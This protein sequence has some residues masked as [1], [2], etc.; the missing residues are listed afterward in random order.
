MAKRHQFG[1]ELEKQVTDIV[2]GEV[3]AGGQ[4][5]QQEIDDFQA[6]IDLF[7]A[8]RAE[9]DYQWMS[10]IFLPEFPAH[11]LTQ[12]SI[13]VAQYFQTRDFCEVYIQDESP[14]ALDAAEATKE[15]LNRTLNRRD[16]YHY[17]K[18]VRAKN[19]NHFKGSVILECCWEQEVKTEPA[20][21][22]ADNDYVYDETGEVVT[23]TDV[24][25]DQFNYDVLDPR[26]VFMD[27]RYCYT[28]QDKDFVI[29]RHNKTL[30]RLKRDA[31]RYGYFNLDILKESLKPE[32]KTEAELAT[33]DKSDPKQRPA[34]KVSE[35]F[36]IYKR[37]GKFWITEDGK[38]GLDKDGEPLDKATLEEV[39]MSVARA[40]NKNILIQFHRQPYKDA[41][42]IPFRPI[43]RG[44]CYIHPTNDNGVGDGKYA[45]ELQVALNDTF[46]LSND[47]TRLA[48]LP[49]VKVKKNVLED[50]D[51]I[52]WEPGH[53]MEVNDKDDITEFK[54]QDNIE[55]A[56]AQMTL[57][58]G[59]MQEVDSIYPTTMGSMPDKTSVTATAVMGAS[60]HSTQR[61]NYK[62]MTFEYTALVE[63]YWMIQQMTWQF[64]K[65]ET[66]EK[67][68]GQ[69]VVNFN[70][71][72]DYFYKPLSQSIETDESKALKVQRWTT[73]LGYIAQMQHP[74]APKLFNYIMMR[75]CELQGDEF[76]NFA[77]GFLSPQFPLV[78]DQQGDQATA[79]G[80]V[81]GSSN[82]YGIDMGNSQGMTREVSNQRG[83]MG[84]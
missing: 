12:S 10:D 65:P 29:I 44:L 74:D 4:N 57:L 84:Y 64:A 52:Y 14:E 25:K 27:S 17:A 36:D 56:L 60:Q 35:P 72:F 77:V 66:G 67:L 42:D 79:G 58:K 22:E 78:Q 83:S 80:A 2:S 20:F 21:N 19:I 53:P 18:F 34:N 39:V 3:V 75:I 9:K 26:N 11:M 5:Q 13:D 1:E 43:I 54:I 15:L 71:T 70:P 38:P 59:A 76:V 51:S 6:V 32:Q 33:E 46:N 31:A 50:T 62:S 40:G 68:M 82:Q 55:G 69:K 48:T 28:L 37:Y 30:N 61:T 7:D 41:N 8:I 24:F 49:T 45:R 81:G 47:R 23:I 73:I 16:L 63:L